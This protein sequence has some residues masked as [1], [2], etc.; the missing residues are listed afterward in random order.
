MMRAMPTPPNE[1]ADVLLLQ[2]TGSPA[3]MDWLGAE[4][5]AVVYQWH[6]DSF[7]TLPVGTEWL[8]RSAACAH[9]AFAL[10]SHLAMQ[11]HI[12]ITPK[13]IAAWRRRWRH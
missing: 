5:Q 1:P 9:Q 12:E 3:A 11:F 13:K 7:T 2:H 8:A 4:P 10:G 6:Y